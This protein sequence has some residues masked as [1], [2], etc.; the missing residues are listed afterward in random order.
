MNV[1][2]LSQ[3]D[4]I[5]TSRVDHADW[6]YR[7]LLAYVMR[8]RFAL[9]LALLEGK[10]IARMLEVGF[11]SGIFLPELA[12]HCA[13]LYG[14]DVHD[15]VPEVSQRLAELGIGVT[16]SRQDA[17]HT[18]FDDGFFE[19]IV[20]VSALEFIDDI[21]AAARELARVLTPGGSLIAVMPG[22]SPLLDFLLRAA[23]GENAQTD[24]GDRRERVLPALLAHFEI[25]RKKRFA[26]IYTAYEFVRKEKTAC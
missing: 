2:L 11:G 23:T 13:S 1:Q 15:E 10:E 9:T 7:P 22:K 24:Y 21:E 3:N 25:R 8:R 17:G 12:R 19:A 6:N 26:P 16:L 5:R 20:A 18:S 4:V 14:I